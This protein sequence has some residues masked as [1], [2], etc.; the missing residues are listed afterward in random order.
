[1]VGDGFV[2]EARRRFE[3]AAAAADAGPMAAYMKHR[4]EFLG[5][6]TPARRALQKELLSA[7]SRP[8]PEAEERVARQLWAQP[9]REFQYLAIDLLRKSWRRAP[10]ERIDLYE[11]LICEKPWWDT[12][13]LLAGRLVGDHFTRFEDRA[14]PRTREWMSSEMM[15]L[16]RSALL[17]QL[18]YKER[19]NADVLFEYVERL[20]ASD[21]FFI[22]KA[23]GWALRQY[24]KTAPDAV[25]RFVRSHELAPLSRREALK[26]LEVPRNNRL[27]DLGR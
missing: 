16:Q 6:K 19:T 26:H 13:D 10:V 24:A 25:R 11:E 2:E 12:V 7:Q 9:E 3:A 5:L 20:A 17:Y 21:E 23:I 14:V 27:Q 8:A 4:F 15:W 1:M 18:H 22:R